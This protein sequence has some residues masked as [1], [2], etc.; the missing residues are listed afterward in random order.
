MSPQTTVQYSRWILTYRASDVVLAIHS[1]TSYL[2]EANARIRAGRHMFKAN[3]GRM[4]TNN[5]AVLNI[6]QII[7]AVMLSAAVA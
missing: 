3:W 2:L 6:L 7:K 4:P 5:E 1:D